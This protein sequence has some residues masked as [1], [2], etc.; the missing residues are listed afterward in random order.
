MIGASSGCT[1]DIKCPHDPMYLK[2]GELWHGTIVYQGHA[3]LLVR[4]INRNLGG[5]WRVTGLSK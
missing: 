5:T 4:G 2:H 3:R 1:A